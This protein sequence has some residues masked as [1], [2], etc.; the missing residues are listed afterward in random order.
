MDMKAI[1]YST[2]VAAGV[3]APAASANAQNKETIPSFAVRD[4]ET[5]LMRYVSAHASCVSSFKKVDSVDVLQGST[6]ELTFEAV[7]KGEVP[8]SYPS[9]DPCPKPLP[10]AA[11]MVTAKNITDA[12]ET[13][14]T[15]RVRMETKFGPWQNIVRARVFVFPSK[16]PQK[17][18]V[19]APQ[20]KKH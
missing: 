12:H 17:I 11:I 16:E 20:E 4:G 7:P 18:Q 9:G 8:V 19:E 14:V 6:D 2:V 5:L 13:V 3:V 10:G 1:L 15:L